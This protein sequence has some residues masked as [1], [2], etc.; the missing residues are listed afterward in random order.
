MCQHMYC[1]APFFVGSRAVVSSFRHWLEGVLMFI[2]LHN[3][4]FYIECF[5]CAKL[6]L[7]LWPYLFICKGRG[8]SLKEFSTCPKSHS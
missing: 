6:T 7:S 1:L 5:L 3:N 2:M 8:E 4:S